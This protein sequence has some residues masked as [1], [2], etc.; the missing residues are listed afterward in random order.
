M[1]KTEPG[2][3]AA[4]VTGVAGHHPSPGKRGRQPGLPA[5]RLIARAASHRGAGDGQP[6]RRYPARGYSVMTTEDLGG[7]H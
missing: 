3:R 6:R 5:G 1:I 7:S 2:G 4:L